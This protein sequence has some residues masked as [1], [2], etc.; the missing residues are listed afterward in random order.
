ML[1][2][3]DASYSIGEFTSTPPPDDP[4]FFAISHW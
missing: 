4:S 1:L 2:D 3:E